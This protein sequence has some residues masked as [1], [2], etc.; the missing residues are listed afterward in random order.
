MFTPR[1]LSQ[2]PCRNNV[3][4][5]FLYKKYST[6]ESVIFQAW[7]LLLVLA[8]HIKGIDF[9]KRREKMTASAAI[10]YFC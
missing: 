6:M 1:Y 4:F 3:I 10:P 9:G 2:T 5:G 8:N 7:L